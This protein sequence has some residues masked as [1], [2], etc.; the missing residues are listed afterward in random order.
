MAL[1]LQG[2]RPE[3]LRQSA[4]DYSQVQNYLQIAYQ[5]LEPAVKR[6]DD[7]AQLLI[8][9]GASIDFGLKHC[10]EQYSLE[11]HRVTIRDCIDFGVQ[12]I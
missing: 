12:K 5:P 7:I 4:S 6:N 3:L 2:L 8:T 11:S 1:Y 9:L 10:L